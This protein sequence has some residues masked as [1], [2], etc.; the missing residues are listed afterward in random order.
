M[1][2]SNQAPT[3]MSSHSCHFSLSSLLGAIFQTS[4]YRLHV[5]LYQGHV[6]FSSH[7]KPS[8]FI[9]IS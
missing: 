3:S 6:P 9:V 5:G 1:S 4:C 8:V 7:S 2:F